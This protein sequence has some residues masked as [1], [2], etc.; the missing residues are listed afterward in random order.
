MCGTC[1]QYL[2]NANAVQALFK[3]FHRCLFQ[4]LLTSSSD[5]RVVL[6]CMAS[7]SSESRSSVDNDF[8]DDDVKKPPLEDGVI[9]VSFGLLDFLIYT[10][11][12]QLVP[13]RLSRMQCEL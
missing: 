3:F 11:S 12:N 4:L 1:T 8:D 10:S 6:C 9:Q 7:I 5:G 2:L 13:F